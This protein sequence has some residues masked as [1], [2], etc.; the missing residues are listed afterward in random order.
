MEQRTLSA[1]YKFYCNK[2]LPVKIAD[3]FIK[4]LASCA[5]WIHRKGV[6]QAYFYKPRSSNEYQHAPIQAA[7]ERNGFVENSPETYN[8]NSGNKIK[9]F[10][11]QLILEKKTVLSNP[12]QGE[13]ANGNS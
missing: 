4:I 7:F 1:A 13:P 9:G 2:D 8:P 12:T 6:M 5:R 11:R 3:E 10:C